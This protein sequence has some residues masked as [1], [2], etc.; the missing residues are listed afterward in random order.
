MI[1]ILNWIERDLGY[2]DPINIIL[3]KIKLL[4]VRLQ[5]YYNKIDYLPGDLIDVSAKKQNHWHSQCMEHNAF[6]L[7]QMHRWKVR[8][9]SMSRCLEPTVPLSSA[10]LCRQS[11]CF[12]GCIGQ[13]TPKIMYLYYLKIII[14]GSNY[15]KDIYFKFE[16][17]IT[18][19]RLISADQQ[20]AA[21]GSVVS[22]PRAQCFCFQN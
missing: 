5:Y 18:G 20:L 8:L 17:K 1:L 6:L 7:S 13:V 22:A 10:A 15:P 19:R 4:Y 11:F 2:F 14:V 9:I 12:S 16:N 3:Y 21:P